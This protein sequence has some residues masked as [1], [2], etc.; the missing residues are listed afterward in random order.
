MFRTMWIIT[1]VLI[2]GGKTI[3]DLGT[4]FTYF[5]PYLREYY[6]AEYNANSNLK[7]YVFSGF[8]RLT[9]YQ[10]VIRI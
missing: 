3:N 8:L 1:K 9:K 6:E 2:N 4:R 7:N 5:G 10:D